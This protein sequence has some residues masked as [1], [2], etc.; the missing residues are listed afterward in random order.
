MPSPKSKA[1][2]LAAKWR[3]VGFDKAH[4]EDGYCVIGCSQ[5]QARVINNI[6]CHEEGCP[7]A[8][9]TAH[10]GMR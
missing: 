3:R 6:P 9:N 1:A 10:A 4:V 2:Q 8:H 5:C 7:N